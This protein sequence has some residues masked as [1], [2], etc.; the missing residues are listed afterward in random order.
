MST[1]FG[2]DVNGLIKRTDNSVAAL[3]KY[4][5][6]GELETDQQ[7]VGTPPL[8]INSFRWHGLAYDSETG[9]YQVRARYYDPATRRFISED[10]I[11]L[12]GGN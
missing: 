3:Y 4:T 6:W 11:G 8:R 7:Y 2:G 10:P 12:G 1:G 5:P 9:L